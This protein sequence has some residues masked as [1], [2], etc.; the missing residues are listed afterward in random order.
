[1][2]AIRTIVRRDGPLRFDAFVDLSLY[3]DGGF[4]VRENGGVAGR[5][6]DFIT[7]P[8]VGPLFGA[9]VA[10]HLDAEWRRLGEPGEF[11][12][13][14]V[15]AGPATLLRSVISA[16][17]ECLP[18]MRPIAVEISDRQRRAHP[19]SIESMASLPDVPFT[20]VVIANELLDNLCFRLAVYDGGWREA[21]VDIDPD[22]RL[23]EVLSA[24][25]EPLPDSLPPTA[26]I[27]SRAPIVDAA[28]AFVGDVL[29]RLV[30]GSLIVVDYGVGRTAEL[31]LRPWRSWLRTFRGHEPGSHYLA[32]PGLQDITTEVPFDQLPEPDALRTQSQYLQLHGIDDLVE[33]GKRVWAERAARPDLVAM[34][35]RSRISEAEALLEP[36]GLGGFLV[37]EWRR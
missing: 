16:A 35:M 11:A 4:Y 30:A 18:A 3:G 20:G 22:G 37:A 36:G 26:S 15:G 5:R 25:I 1:M 13:V 27:G 10:R 19:E 8:E 21:F 23:C 7:S 17:P 14:D 33:E 2:D 28:S 32:E 29:D 31:A 34:T 6:G 12:V 9:V 24:P